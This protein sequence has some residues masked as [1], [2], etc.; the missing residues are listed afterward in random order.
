[1]LLYELRNAASCLVIFDGLDEVRD[2]GLRIQVSR[3]I[4]DFMSEYETG[5]FFVIT[6]RVAGYAEAQLKGEFKHYLISDFDQ[7]DIR[8]FVQKW[9]KA[10]EG[11]TDS[12]EV[13]EGRAKVEAENLIVEIWS[14]PGVMK[15][16]T[17]PLLLT[18]LALVHYQGMHLPPRRVDLYELCIKTL[19]G[20]WN[21]ARSLA[22]KPLKAW[23]GS[24]V[25]DE[26]YIVRILGPVS[27]WMRENTDG[28]I[29]KSQLVDLISKELEKTQG[30]KKSLAREVAGDFLDLIVIYCGLIIEVAPNAFSFLHLTFEEYLAAKTLT[31]RRDSSRFVLTILDNPRWRET[32]LLT[33]ALLP[34][35]YADE[36]VTNI[37][38]NED[39]Y[40]RF[41]HRHLMLACWC[42][43]DD[44]PISYEL[45]KELLVSII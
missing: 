42:L 34:G 3:R 24:T 14:N 18:I 25:L 36:F 33:A 37:K 8:L 22:N 39:F 27:L 13:V 30:L 31:G 6:S 7:S 19:A 15:L 43:V 4:Q 29:E 10:F 12:E 23:L 41:L 2:L 40:E 5:N 21:Q 45:R 20:T 1:M 44:S 38:D 26:K 9:C 28:V 16:A 17:N 32:I 11:I 35:D